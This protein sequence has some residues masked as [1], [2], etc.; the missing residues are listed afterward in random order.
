MTRR[1]D[2]ETGIAICTRIIEGET[3][4]EICEDP[5]LPSQRTIYRWLA[6]IPTFWQLYARAREALMDRW[7]DEIIEIADDSSEDYVDHIGADGVV[8]RRFDPEA[9]QR[10]KLRIETRKWLMSKLASRR[11]GD[12]IDV[13]MQATTTPAANLTDDELTA[14]VMAHLEAMGIAVTGPLLLGHGQV[15]KP[16][17]DEV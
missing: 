16:P 12:K 15:G 9:V 1:Y 6:A 14:R 3:I 5:D 7:A 8:E 10:S 2:E 13:N 17:A 11:Y 4:K